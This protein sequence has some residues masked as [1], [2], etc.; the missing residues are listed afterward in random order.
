M[1]VNI[2]IKNQADIW[3]KQNPLLL[4]NEEKK[5]FLI[6]LHEYLENKSTILDDEVFDF[7]VQKKFIENKPREISF[8]NYLTQKYINLKNY[9]VLDVGAGRICSLS[10]SITQTGAKCTAIDTNIRLNNETLRKAKITPI[11]KLFVCDEFSKN[12]VGTNIQNYDLIV[13][14]EPCDAT[15]HIIRQSLKYN[16]P[17]DINLCASPHKALNGET[18]KTYNEWYKH[19]SSISHEVS[20]IENECGFIATN[21]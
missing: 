16:K 4:N 13:G 2:I 17:F 10:K 6:S 1:I 8:I 9:R 5:K 18:F 21:N 14:L 7:L 12:S 19:L 20:I 3:L 15:E 11:K